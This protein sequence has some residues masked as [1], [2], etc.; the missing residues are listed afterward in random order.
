MDPNAAL[1]EGCF[2]SLFDWIKRGGFLPKFDGPNVEA[3]KDWLEQ[4]TM[5]WESRK[6]RYTARYILNK[7][8]AAQR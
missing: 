7:I 3:F 1:R 8:K 6:D 5:V 4:K 2:A